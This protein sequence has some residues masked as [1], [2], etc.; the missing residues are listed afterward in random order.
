MR[1]SATIAPRSR[2]QTAGGLLAAAALAMTGLAAFA[3]GYVIYILWPRW[4]EPPI[5]IDAPVVPVTVGDVLFRIPPGAIRQKVQRR[6]GAQDR[7]D[8]IYVWPALTPA[9]TLPKVDQTIPTDRLFVTIATTTSA[10]TPEERLKTIYPRYTDGVLRQGPDGLAM[11]TFRDN[12]P[13]R[14]ED[15]MYDPQAPERFM[16]R[17]T[18]DNPPMAGSC[19]YERFFAATNVTVRFHRDWLSDWRKVQGSIE[20]LMESLQ[21]ASAN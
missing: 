2:R 10:M 15:V 5:A 17:C 9:A 16:V 8:L 12:S 13:Y 3:L 7:I 19:I 18:R 6:P 20:Q 1:A 4:P 14:G 11:Q 21:P